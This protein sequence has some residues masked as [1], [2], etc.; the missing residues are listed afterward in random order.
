MVGE[1]LNH[2]LEARWQAAEAAADALGQAALGDPE[3]MAETVRRLRRRYGVTALALFGP[4]GD[5][6]VWDGTH[7]GRVPEEVQRGLR[8]YWYGDLP[9]F[10]Y[11]YVT[12]SSMDQGTAMA[13]ILLRTDLP[14]PMGADAGDFAAEFRKEVGESV[15]IVRAGSG[16]GEGGWDLTLGDRTLFSVVLEPPERSTRVAEILDRWRLIVGGLALGSWLLLAA[17]GLPRLAAGGVAA[18]ALLFL[19]AALPFQLIGPLAPLFDGGRFRLAGPIPLSLGRLAALTFAGVTL[20]AV[21]P[22]PRRRVPPVVAGVLAALSAPLLLAWLARGALPGALAG[23][24]AFWV[25]YQGTAG[26]LL[27]L[28]VGTLLVLAPA[29]AE[30]RPFGVAA[31]A[32]GG[33]LG[34]GSAAFVWMSGSLPIWW[35]ALWGLPVALAAGSMGSRPGWQPSLASWVL[36][37]LIALT[38]AIPAAWAHRVEAR[39]DRASAY[40]ERLAAPDDPA[41]ELALFHLG[42]S[43]DSLSRSG[44]RGVDLLYGAWRRSGLAEL[45]EPAWLTLWSSA[46]IPEEE[47]R[48]GVTERPVVASEVQEDPGPAPGLRILRYNRDDARYVLRVTLASGEILTAAAPPFAD[49]LAGAPL[50]P[51]LAGGATREPPPLTLIPV[52]DGAADGPPG[53]HWARTRDGW[54][55][56]RLLRY[57]NG[58]DYH[59]HYGVPLPGV[60]LATA[61]ATLL[62]LADM[63]LFLALRAG[64][65]SFLRDALPKDLR[66]TG[67]MISFRARVTLALFGFFVLANAIFGTLAYR[68]IADAS[69]RTAQVLADRVAEDAAGWYFEVGGRMQALARRVGVE[70]LE[71]R[72]GELRDGS[73]EELVELGLYEGWVPMDVHRLLA[74]REDVRELHGDPA[75]RLG[76]RHR[77]P[78][79]ARRRRPRR[80]GAPAG[81]CHRHPVRGRGGVAGFRGDGRRGAVARPGTPGGARAH[82]ADP[83]APGGVGAGGWRA[84]WGCASLRSRGR[85]RR[86]VPRVQPH[87]RA[88]AARPPSARAHHPTDPGHHGGGRRGHGGPGPG[89]AGHP[90]E[91]PGRRL[92]SRATY[93]SVE[94]L[95]V[96]RDARGGAGA[97]LQGF[98]AGDDEESDVELHCRGPASPCPGPPPGDRGDPGWCGGGARGRHRRAAHRAG[99]GLGGDGAAGGARGEEPAHADQAQR[100][101]HPAGL[102]RPTA[103]LRGH[104]GAQRRRRC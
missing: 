42:R 64:G 74:G 25:V 70:L 46:G 54:Q 9:L 85:V 83:G 87:G 33:A 24:E 49:P 5:L 26:I 80:P 60:W 100:P 82:P 68:T 40:L 52:E 28:L 75:R 18:S 45:G 16:G 34:V 57:S 72:G 43:A 90:G 99:A 10:G 55:A 1:R 66:W 48:V 29:R 51:L 8:R 32:L 104:P 44:E 36:A 101:A 92:C 23:S 89:G 98:M 94:P 15:R 38:A 17:G 59:A 77:L 67:L 41:L 78:A 37:G 19:A 81:R 12:A 47:L 6:R 20:V 22:R 97:W 84:T 11:L 93:R 53:L 102:G 63:L 2:E 71:Y 91:P 76:V 13:A 65:R 58:V 39:L 86:G 61:R 50:S 14:G 27:T 31:V 56:E 73:V 4:S 79:L 69:H 95:P 3:G 30:R 21:L 96:E 88:S 62:L 103:R 35:L 7:R